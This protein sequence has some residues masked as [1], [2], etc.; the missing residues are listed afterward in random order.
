MP[1]RNGECKKSSDLGRKRLCSSWNTELEVMMVHLSGDAQQ[2]GP[3]TQRAT[4]SEGWLQCKAK[5]SHL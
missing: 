4:Q 5:A 1:I 3:G 2:A